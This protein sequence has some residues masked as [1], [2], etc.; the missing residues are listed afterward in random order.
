MRQPGSTGR[1]IKIRP[2]HK[3]KEEKNQTFAGFIVPCQQGALP[4]GGAVEMLSLPPSPRPLLKPLLCGRRVAA[5]TTLLSRYVRERCSNGLLLLGVVA[6]VNP[7][8]AGGTST[9]AGGSCTASRQVKSMDECPPDLNPSRPPLESMPKGT[10]G[11]RCDL[12]MPAR[13][14][15]NCFVSHVKEQRTTPNKWEGHTLFVDAQCLFVPE[16]A[17]VLVELRKWECYLGEIDTM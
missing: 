4:A 1:P 8:V 2:F 13:H 17:S 7:P 15:K 5:D 10:L 6:C 11:C 3:K 14:N 9:G 16:C 12:L